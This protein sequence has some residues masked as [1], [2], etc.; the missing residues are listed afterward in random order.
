MKRNYKNQGPRNEKI[1]EQKKNSK[2]W[3][4]KE[5]E[6]KLNETKKKSR[7]DKRNEKMWESFT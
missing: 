6:T 2:V 4:G 5:F 3:K 7:D 1:K